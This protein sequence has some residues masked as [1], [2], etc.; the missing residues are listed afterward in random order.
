MSNKT[1]QMNIEALSV[2]LK[3]WNQELTLM[4]Q[5]GQIAAQNAKSD[6]WLGSSTKMGQVINHQPTDS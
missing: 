4:P 2:V 1:T 3:K 5:S 6:S